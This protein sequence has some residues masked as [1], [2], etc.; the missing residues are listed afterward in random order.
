[1][2]A[3]GR[4]YRLHD[5]GSAAKSHRASS[6]RPQCRQIP[7]RARAASKVARL[8]MRIRL[9]RTLSALTLAACQG[10]SSTP[11]SAQSSRLE[12]TTNEVNTSRQTAITQ[13]V[14]R[15]A[16]SVV[17]VQTEVV[18]RVP[19]D[20]FEQFFGG[21]SGQRAA[22]GLGS[23]FIVRPDGAIVT[24]AHVV[25]GATRISVAMKDGTTYPARLLGIDETN[26]LAVLKID[27]RNLPVAPLGSSSN[28]LIGEW[29][30]AIGNPYG[31][32]L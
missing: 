12:T 28:L 17:T 1:M 27:A 19:A 8:H 15:V 26:D 23:G 24:N 5:S 7:E 9:A 11:S 29:A 2:R 20:V 16:P 22:A 32:I 21:R 14:A 4:G 6:Q 10:A 18:E 13:A 31:F 3:C 25:A 30:I